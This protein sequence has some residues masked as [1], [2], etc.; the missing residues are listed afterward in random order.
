MK[1]ILFLIPLFYSPNGVRRFLQYLHEDG[2]GYSYDV[3]LPCSNPRIFAAAK[4]GADA[5]GFTC[6]ERENYGGGEGALWWL[7]KQSGVQISDYRYVWYFEESCEPVRRRWQRRL[8]GDMDGGIPLTGWWWNSEGRRRPHSIPHVVI[9]R[10]GSKMIYN[11]NT[12]GSGIDQGGRAFLKTYDTPHY[13]DDTFVVRSSD[14]LEFDYP[15]ARDPFWEKWSGLRTYGVKAE[16]VWWSEDDMDAHGLL[17]RPPNIQWYVLG[18]HDYVPSGTNRYRSYF[19]DLPWKLKVD[20]QY[21]PL[22]IWLRTILHWPDPFVTL[23]VS[24]IKRSWLWRPT[25]G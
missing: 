4:R 5:A 12:T 19:R 6:V 24:R 2:S 1:D 14:F 10:D 16:R 21:T 13:R 22:P 20:D 17:V 11:E 25:Y 23:A 18:K 9:G 3:F 15:N 8:I 7:Q